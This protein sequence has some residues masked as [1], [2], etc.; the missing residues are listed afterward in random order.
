MDMTD[1]ELSAE[2]DRLFK[3]FSGRDPPR[4]D[5]GTFDD[6][7]TKAK[8]PEGD[9]AEA[10]RLIEAAAWMRVDK[11][12]RDKFLHVVWKALKGSAKIDGLRELWNETVAKAIAADA[13]TPGEIAKMKAEAAEA[14]AEA[15]RSGLRPRGSC[16]SRLGSPKIRS[17]S[18]GC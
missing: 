8:Q 17:C 12:E 3:E 14:E 16:L 6:F 9:T 13:P 5:E 4:D 1:E 2:Y 11:L 10:R 15:K 18:S 7:L